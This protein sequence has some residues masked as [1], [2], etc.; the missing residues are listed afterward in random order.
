MEHIYKSIFEKALLAAHLSLLL[1]FLLSSWTY[2]HSPFVANFYTDIRIIPFR[3]E[4]EIKK[5]DPT[6]VGRILSICNLI[7]I[8]CARGLH[9]QFYLWYF[10]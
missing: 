5:L 9:H 8:L 1:L 7:G 4:V 3:Y 10:W 6:E 2:T